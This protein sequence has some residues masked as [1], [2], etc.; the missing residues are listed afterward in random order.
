MKKILITALLI[1]FA[2]LV[3]KIFFVIQIDDSVD[4]ITIKNSSNSKPIYIKKYTRGLNYER[5]VIT[6]QKFLLS[7]EIDTEI[8]HSDG[9]IFFYKFINDTLVVNG[10]SW[11]NK[12]SN[13]IG[14]HILIKEFSNNVEFLRFRKSYS[15]KGFKCYPEERVECISD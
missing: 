1:V 15:S 12:N 14:Y 5:V 4:T 6:K 8:V 9:S 11:L 7:K 2:M 13:N 3:F 10:G